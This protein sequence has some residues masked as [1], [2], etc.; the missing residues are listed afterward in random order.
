[1]KLVGRWVEASLQNPLASGRG[2]FAQFSGLQE[3]IIPPFTI[4]RRDAIE[5]AEGWNTDFITTQDSELNMRLVNDGWSLFRSDSSYCRMA[6]RTS[7]SG[8]LRFG[9]RYGFWR[10]K[11]LLKTPERASILEFLPWIG[12]LATLGLCWSGTELL[13]YP[14]WQIPVVAYLIVLIL[15]SILEAISHSQIS[16]IIGLPIMLILL[17]IT[18]SLGL[19]DGLLRRGRAPKDRIS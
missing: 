8:W 18:F 19:L 14:T 4:Y 13:G 2:Q 9:H 6:K 12:L 17:H 11:H 16:L 10:T 1:L 7:I 5:A 3:T 15:H